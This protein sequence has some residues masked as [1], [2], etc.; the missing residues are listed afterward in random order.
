MNGQFAKAG[1][2]TERYRELEHEQDILGGSRSISPPQ[3][4][5]ELQ[6]YW[7]LYILIAADAGHEFLN[8]RILN[9]A[10]A[11]FQFQY[12]ITEA[13]GIYI[14]GTH[15]M[16]GGRTHALI[17]PDSRASWKNGRIIIALL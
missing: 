8:G 9:V 1:N 5:H 6:K 16:A 2:L 17:I 12:R 3:V 10:A 4:K 13:T 15:Y 14:I 7:V 11:Y